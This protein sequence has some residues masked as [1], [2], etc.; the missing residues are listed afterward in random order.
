MVESF[1]DSDPKFGPN[2]QSALNDGIIDSRELGEAFIADIKKSKPKA[3]IILLDSFDYFQLDE[4]SFA[5]FAH[6]IENL[7]EGTQLL[8]NSRELNFQLWGPYVRQGIA[9]MLGDES[10]L[11]G[12]IYRADIPVTPHLEIYGFGG[13]VVYV[14]GVEVTVWDGPLPRNLFYYFVDHQLVTRDEIFETF[15]PGLP[16]KE[17]TNVF[18]VTKRKV[19]ER[20][21]YELT[22]YSSGF[23]RPS[24]QMVSHYDVARFEQAIED[25]HAQDGHAVDIW[26][27]AIKVYRSPFLYGI[28]MPW[29]EERREKLKL[30]YAEA[31]IGVARALKAENNAEYA[32]AYYLRAQREVPERE[33][34][35][36]ELMHLYDGNGQRDKAI[37]QYRWLAGILKRRLG[38]TPSKPTRTVY[39]AIV[40][41]G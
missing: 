41:K 15:W 26:M 24:D 11:D 32:I 14:N 20:L 22:S 1:R 8:L 5:F 3:K 37:A 19:S 25:A 34:V 4:D 12:G 35:T 7:P 16:A 30:A 13:G 2:L 28:S 33:D 31:L 29:I 23:Y 10:N 27:R 40:A 39:D 18:H 9:V 21:G 36:R 6:V 38:I 17:A